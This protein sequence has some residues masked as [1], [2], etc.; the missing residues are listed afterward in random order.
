MWMHN[1]HPL[2]FPGVRS[3][4]RQEFFLLSYTCPVTLQL[5]V[6]PFMIASLHTFRQHTHSLLGSLG[7][8]QLCAMLYHYHS[9]CPTPLS[10][11]QR[12]KVKPK[13]HLPV[14]PVALPRFV[15]SHLSLVHRLFISPKGSRLSCTLTESSRGLSAFLVIG[16][17]EPCVCPW[18]VLSFRSGFFFF[19]SPPTCFD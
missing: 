9:D 7:W 10:L 16:E 14:G 17:M 18:S 2:C 4:G 8:G 6:L 3:T 11:A 1:S 19:C 15:G 5:S 13:L 12:K